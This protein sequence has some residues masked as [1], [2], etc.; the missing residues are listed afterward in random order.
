[1]V[2]ESR[3]YFLFSTGIT[4]QFY[5]GYRNINMQFLNAAPYMF[6]RDMQSSL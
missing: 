1:M 6:L 3:L 4:A 2:L 5:C